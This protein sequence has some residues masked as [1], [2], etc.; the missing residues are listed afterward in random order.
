MITV[1]VHQA[2]S[3]RE[4]PSIDPDWLREESGAVVWADLVRPTPEETRILSEVFRFHPLAV[5]DALSASHHPKIETYDGV[6]YLILHGIDFQASK[7]AF[8]THDTDFFLGPG[9]LVTVHDGTTRSIEETR[10]IC[11]RNPRVLGEGPAALLHRIVDAMVDH[12]GPEVEKLENKLDRLEAWVVSSPRESALKAILQIKRDVASLRRV[13]LP[14]RDVINRLARREFSMIDGEIAY[15]FRDVYDHLVRISDEAFIFQ[16]RV[17]A[18]LE[19]HLTAVSN[20]LNQIMKVLTI[21]ATIFMP[22]TVVT[23]LFGMNVRLPRLPG[24]DGAQFWWIAA[25]MMGL[26]AAMLVWFNRRRWL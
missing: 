3:T 14:Q 26:A 7:H 16:D 12:Y 2:G 24:P 5:E 21:I 11:C 15:R 23:G 13:T 1:L 10:A 9:Y 18:L 4:A 6:L 22:M 25:L 8:A 17:N 19:V 20:R